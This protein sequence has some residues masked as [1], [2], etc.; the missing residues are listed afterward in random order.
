MGQLKKA[1]SPISQSVAGKCMLSM[2]ACANASVPIEASWE[3][4]GKDMNDREA[5]SRKQYSPMC[6][7]LAGTH[8]V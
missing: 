4:G 6:C 5:Q 1:D 3:S 7:K 8:K 2:P